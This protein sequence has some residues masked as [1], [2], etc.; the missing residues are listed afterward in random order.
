MANT[1]TNLPL[2]PDGQPGDA[3]NQAAADAADRTAASA[4]EAADQAAETADKAAEAAA[5]KTEEAG[6]MIRQAAESAVQ[7]GAASGEAAAAEAEKEVE[8][9][10]S[11]EPE[12]SGTEDS[13]DFE[14]DEYDDYDEV[15][16]REKQQKRRRRKS[17]KKRKSRG[18]SCSLVLL[19]FIC[20][21]AVAISMVI[22]T[23]VKE[24]YGIEKDESRRNITI[25]AGSTT[26]DIANQ[27]SRDGL[28]SLPKMFRLISRMNGKDGSYIA[29]EH[30]ISASMSYQAMI[31]ELCKN[32]EEDR[33]Y[34]TVTFAEGITLYDAAQ[35]LEANDVCPADK[36]LWAFNAGGYGFSFEDRVTDT[37]KL[38]F[39]RM[40]G[41][42]FPDT[43]NFYVN[44]DPAI[45][46]QKIYEN[47]EKKMLPTDYAKMEELGWSLDQVI[48][49]ASIVQAESGNKEDMK[50][51]ASV[52]H[53]RIL[54]SAVYPQLQSNPTSNYVRD[55]I[56]PNQE[57]QNILMQDAYDTYIGVGLPPGAIGNP[58]KDAIEA[59]LYPAQTDYFY[60]YANVDTRVT[61]FARTNEEHEQNIAM[62]K[63]MREEAAKADQ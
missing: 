41:Y 49:L 63:K 20:A 54:N 37:S 17:R 40:E 12:Q 56:K 52:F 3:V 16:E 30:V 25:P 58:G 42:C 28:I 5:E 2:T 24:I 38:K 22:L 31:E 26:A 45:V 32:H 23:V 14:D 55:V 53:N 11:D 27:L 33:E 35:K 50:G 43:Y 61:Y 15:R 6:S 4:G 34:V 51:I 13:E 48:T 62:V 18:L 39:Y 19:T 46:A 7:A 47:F 21:S 36:F 44:E 59:V 9:L 8:Q 57:V 1:E 29:G 10:F 60:F